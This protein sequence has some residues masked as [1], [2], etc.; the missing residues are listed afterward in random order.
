MNDVPLKARRRRS[1]QTVSLRERLL[2]RAELA[3]EQASHLPPGY[4]KQVLMRTAQQAEVVA[5]LEASLT[6]SN[7]QS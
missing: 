3:R 2:K 4:E 5:D 6:R 7:S 1:K